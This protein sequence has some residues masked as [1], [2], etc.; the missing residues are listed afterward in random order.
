MSGG[1]FMPLV[2]IVSF[3]LKPLGRCAGR[4]AALLLGVAATVAAA[5]GPGGDAEV[6]GA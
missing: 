1:S 3:M 6:R 4:G 5:A 2:P